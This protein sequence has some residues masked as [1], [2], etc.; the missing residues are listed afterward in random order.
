MH[1]WQF[2]REA[3]QGKDHSGI[4]PP[5]VAPDTSRGIAETRG[6]PG[7]SR[8][9]QKGGRRAQTGTNCN[10]VRVDGLLLSIPL[11][12]DPGRL[13][14]ILVCENAETPGLCD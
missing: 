6:M 3:E 11:H 2:A 14:P 1:R 10:D 7:S 8:V 5:I 13:C 4:M 12:K 9:E